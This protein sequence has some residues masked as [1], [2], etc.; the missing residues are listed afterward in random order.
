MDN[1]VEIQVIFANKENEEK[2]AEILK[3]LVHSERANFSL[4]Y[5]KKIGETLD[6]FDDLV[7]IILAGHQHPDYY[8]LEVDEDWHHHAH[9]FDASYGW[10]GVMIDM[11]ELIT[12]CI[13]DESEFFIDVDE[14][15]DQFVIKGRKCIQI[16]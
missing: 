14:D 12:P 4:D 1:S 8:D 13:E 15:Y 7:K 10:E 9:D 2:A 11:F 16:H 6:T 5:W 3:E